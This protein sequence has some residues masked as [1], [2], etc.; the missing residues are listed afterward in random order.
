MAPRPAHSF[1]QSGLPLIVLTVGGWLGLSYFMKARYDGQVRR[2][3]LT[4]CAAC[5]LCAPPLLS[6]CSVCRCPGCHSH[7]THCGLE[8]WSAAQE[9][10]AQAVDLHAPV[11]RQRAKRFDLEGELARLRGS[12][13][14]A[15][16][17]N[18]PIPRPREM[19]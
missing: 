4:L 5:N 16:Y 9:A 8:R 6:L 11:E 19:E 1:V 17:S 12:T 3:R 18:K 7:P 2:R 13:S 15:E 14:E 10:Q